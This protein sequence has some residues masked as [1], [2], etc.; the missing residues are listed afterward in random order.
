MDCD[1]AYA[2]STVARDARCTL[3]GVTLRTHGDQKSATRGAVHRRGVSMARG[4][5]MLRGD[6]MGSSSGDGVRNSSVGA[7]SRCA[8]L[9]FGVETAS[10]QCYVSSAD[11]GWK[12]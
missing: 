8:I 11:W 10:V 4:K 12:A 6:A 2:S 1:S 7:A 5:T 3:R 9:R